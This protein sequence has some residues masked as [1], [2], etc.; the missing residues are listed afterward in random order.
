MAETSELLD[1]LGEDG[2][3][4]GQQKDRAAVHR[5]GDW[6]RSFHLGIMNPAG[7]VL[8]QR[9]SDDKAVEPG[10]IDVSVGGHFAAGEDLSDVLR[11]A[12]EELGFLPELTDLHQLHK[13]HTERFYD[14]LT[15]REFQDVYA[16]LR[17]APLESYQPDCSE[18]PVLYE[19]PIDSAIRLFR[20]LEP[21]A[22]AGWDCQGRHNNALLFEDDL[23]HR[24]RQE[25]VEILGTLKEWWLQGR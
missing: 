18:V 14:G 22:V 7:L 9:R 21:V 24:A 16:L 8:F 12:E 3:K 19:V 5:D 15:D 2:L 4:T 6:H 20:D 11:E 25:T 13:R 10:R 1:V 23:I 17:D